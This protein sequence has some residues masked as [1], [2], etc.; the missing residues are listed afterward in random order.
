MNQNNKIIFLS[1]PTASG[2]SHLALK[3]A[4]IINGEIINAD[5]MQVYKE[6]DILTAR[7]S[8]IDQKNIKHHLYGHQTGKNRYNVNK[9]CSECLSKINEIITN[10]KNP[11]IVGGTGL[12]FTCLINGINYVP[13][14]PE[15]VKQDSKKILNKFGYDEF[16]KLVNAIDPDSCSKIKPN[17]VHR[18]RRVWEVHNYTG[19]ILSNWLIKEKKEFIK[20][21]TYKFILLLPERKNIYER[22]NERFIKMIDK[23]AIQE[24]KNLYKKN[25]DYNL[26]IMKAHGVPEIKHYLDGNITLKEAINRSQKTTRNYVKRQFTWWRWSKIRPDQIIDGFPSNIDLNNLDI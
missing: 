24:V 18:L 5:S 13:I 22:C 25:F 6:L 11:I 15:Y 7:P 4:E 16:Y 8:K 12:Y 9:W 20:N 10:K 17:D 23:G 14:I 3:L 2:K 26:P 19:I 21:Y 1:G